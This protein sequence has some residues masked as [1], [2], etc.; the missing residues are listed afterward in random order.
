M[1]DYIKKKEFSQEPITYSVADISTMLKIS[2]SSAYQLV[3]EG[4]FKTIRIG[5]MIRI[6]KQSFDEW[7][8]KMQS[9]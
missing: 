8:E 3:Q 6:S 1:N 5:K 2:R 4:L 7:F 9:E